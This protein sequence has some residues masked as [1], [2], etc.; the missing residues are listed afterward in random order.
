MTKTPNKII[1][2]ECGCKGLQR[3]DLV[4]AKIDG[5][6]AWRCPNHAKFTKGRAISAQITC[7]D[8]LAVFVLPINN[9]RRKVRCDSCQEK[10]GKK[11]AVVTNEK[12]RQKMIARK[13]LEEANGQTVITKKSQSVGRSIWYGGQ[14]E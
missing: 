4:H 7:L 2:C 13:K 9:A 12:Y 6:T 10:H 3:K 14:N 8:C 1:L 5:A 11:L